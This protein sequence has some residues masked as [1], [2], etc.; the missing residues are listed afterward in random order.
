MSTAFPWDNTDLEAPGQVH[1][2]SRI[3]LD[4]TLVWTAETTCARF[5]FAMDCASLAWAAK[6][7]KTDEA[8]GGDSGEFPVAQC[9]TGKSGFGRGWRCA[10]PNRAKLASNYLLRGNRHDSSF[11]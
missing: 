2:V 7:M 10:A 1:G 6:I 9:A 8:A 3:R 11:H 5:A 4:S